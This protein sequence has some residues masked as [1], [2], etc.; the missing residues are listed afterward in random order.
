[1]STARLSGRYRGR[2]R[3]VVHG[4]LV[5]TV[6]TDTTAA[7]NIADQTR[8]ALR[9]LETNLDDAGS[10]K[11]A[12]LQVTIYLSNIAMKPEMDEVWCEWICTEENWPQRACV[13]V[14]LAGDDMIEIVATAALI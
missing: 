7:D 4:G 12:L 9:A 10:S 8:N 1:M 13:G 3:A 11:Q 2:C 14:D 5:Y 6:S